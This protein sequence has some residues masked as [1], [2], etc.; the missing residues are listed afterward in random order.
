MHFRFVCKSNLFVLAS[1]GSGD[2]AKSGLL[3]S[4]ARKIMKSIPKLHIGFSALEWYSVF[5]N[6]PSSVTP[7]VCFTAEAF[8]V[9]KY[10]FLSFII[11]LLLSWNK[12]NKNSRLQITFVVFW[13]VGFACAIQAAPSH[14]PAQA[15]VSLHRPALESSPGKPTK[16]IWG[17]Y[18]AS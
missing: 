1:L 7:V 16:L 15:S 6:E 17:R 3:E 8:V 13:R 10:A 18:R 2:H 14:N 11:A 9:V 4:W 12:S 5:K